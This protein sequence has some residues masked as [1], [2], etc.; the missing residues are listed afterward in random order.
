MFR[1]K[2]TRSEQAR[3]NGAKSRGPKAQEGRLRSANARRK[4]GIYAV[5]N[6]TD[7]LLDAY[8]LLA[9]NGYPG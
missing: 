4:H 3:I 2:L 7:D 8:A 5:N 6:S 1:K 9:F